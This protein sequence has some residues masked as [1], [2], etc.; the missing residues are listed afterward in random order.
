MICLALTCSTVNENLALLKTHASRIDL[1]ELR[2]DL[3]STDQEEGIAD[4]PDQV[5]RLFSSDAKRV[6]PLIGTVRRVADGGSFRKSESE[7]LELL[8]RVISAGYSY[9]D[10]ESDLRESP[11]GATLANRARAAGCRVIRSVHDTRSQPGDAASLLRQLSDEGREIAKLAVTP[12]SSADLLALLAA[13]DETSDVEKILIGMGPFGVASRILSQ[14]F[15]SLLTY[16]SD[17]DAVQ[18]APGH[19]GPEQMECLYRFRD[20]TPE[21]RYFGVIGSPI[22]HSRSPEYHNGRFSDDRINARY[23]P[24]LV[25]DLPPFLELAQRLPLDGFSVTIPHK[26][27]VLPFLASVDDGTTAAGSCNTVVAQAG[28][29][30]SGEVRLW[31]GVNTDVPGFLA[32]LHEEMGTGLAGKGATVIGAGGAARAIVFVLVR[33][34]MRVLVLNRS[35]DRA[36]QLADDLRAVAVGR[37]DPDARSLTADPPSL[38]AGSP[39]LTAGALSP[40]TRLDDHRD[41]IVQTTSLGMHGKGN[42]VPWLEFRGN[43]VVY[44]IVYTPPETPLIVRARLAGCRTITG[45]R[46]FA[47]QADAQY[48]LFSRL[49]V[50]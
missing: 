48:Q 36:T 22:S 38:I 32:P 28:A 6:L 39:S 20:I 26:S 2:I 35:P 43:E 13:A 25:D 45:D 14:R 12:G 5:S 31:S 11:A 9:V 44:D 3:L 17:P 10:L 46:M 47:A 4:F 41:L 21:T 16:V 29:A 49:A 30:P 8:S 27:A 33:A 50:S 40:E 23:L 42:P 24:F 1:A 18:A 34:G 15:G 37:G 19:I 7:R